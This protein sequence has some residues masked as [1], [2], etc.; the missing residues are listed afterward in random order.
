MGS[1]TL[2]PGFIPDGYFDNDNIDFIR[3]KVVKLSLL[4]YTAGV[5]VDRASV[6]RIMDRVLNERIEPVVK[7]N[8]RVIMYLMDEIRNH[9]LT[10][11]KHLRYEENYIESQRLYDPTVDRAG[12]DIW[13]IKLSNKLGRS[14]VGGT[15]RFYFTF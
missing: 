11:S 9:Q 6:I 5:N 4:E 14:T 7:M 15:T 8:Q 3:D 13:G 10:I 2:F 1:H 12:V